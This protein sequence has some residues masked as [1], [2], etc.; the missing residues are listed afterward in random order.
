MRTS[1]VLVVDDEAYIRALILEI[2]TED[3]YKVTV[4]ADAAQA[5]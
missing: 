2:L 4:A 3:G 5:R 1:H